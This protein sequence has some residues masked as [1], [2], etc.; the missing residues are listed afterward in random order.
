[1][2]KIKLK[3]LIGCIALF[4]SLSIFSHANFYEKKTYFNHT[5]VEKK[6]E[7]S[8]KKSDTKKKK[9]EEEK[10]KVTEK[11]K[12]KKESKKKNKKLGKF[13]PKGF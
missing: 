5:P 10:K 1:M 7:K 13:Y 4:F 2:I 6:E 8:E 12:D 11:D 9:D 3:F